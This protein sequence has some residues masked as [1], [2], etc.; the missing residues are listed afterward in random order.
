[1]WQKHNRKEKA[2]FHVWKG[3]HQKSP[4][5]LLHLNILLQAL[6]S[7]QPRGVQPLHAPHTPFLEHV[8]MMG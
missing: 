5:T 2:D 8:C 6:G 1:M 3:M 4:M 7:R